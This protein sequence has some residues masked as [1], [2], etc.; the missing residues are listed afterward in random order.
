MAAKLAVSCSSSSRRRCG[1][2]EGITMLQ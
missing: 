1:L 2:P